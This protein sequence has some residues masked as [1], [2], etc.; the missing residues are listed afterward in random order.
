[1][2]DISQRLDKLTPVALPIL[3]NNLHTKVCDVRKARVGRYDWG[4]TS[5]DETAPQSCTLVMLRY[6]K[7]IYIWY[8]YIESHANGIK[9]IQVNTSRH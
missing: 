7:N 8:R 2:I 5:R 9:T 3:Y 1:M 6:I 4:A